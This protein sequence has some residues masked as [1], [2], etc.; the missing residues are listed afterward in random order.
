MPGAGIQLFDTATATLLALERG[1]RGD[2]LR[3]ALGGSLLNLL[4]DHLR[5]LDATR[6]NQL[7]GVRS[8][9]YGNAAESAHYT[10]SAA[11]VTL[12]VTEQGF[13]QRYHGGDIKPGAGKEWLTLPARSEAYGHR[14]GEFDLEFIP[15]RADL[16]L[17]A[18]KD[19]NRGK[20]LSVSPK[21]GKRTTRGGN[22]QS[23]LVMY[24]LVKEVHQDEDH[25]VIPTEA[26]FTEA[27]Q[28]GTNDWL[29]TLGARN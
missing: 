22:I 15:I 6:A 10:V 3:H 18:A 17:L 2:S 27:M 7:G 19:G 13:G 5:G 11:G 9:F 4:Q 21:T 16:A 26:Q 1:L 12:S 20:Y 25:S 23:G 8:H 24:W 29:A 14:A 28:S